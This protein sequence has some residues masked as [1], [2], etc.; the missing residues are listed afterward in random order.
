MYQVQPDISACKA[1][2][3]TAETVN[4]VL[5]SVNEI[6][7]LHRL[8]PVGYS[9]VD[10]PAAMSAALIMVANSKLDHMPP[11]TS[12]CFSD[13]GAAGARASNLANTINPAAISF[14]SNDDYLSDFL[15]ETRNGVADNVGHRRWMLDP[16]LNAIAFGRVA[17]RF[18]G[19][20]GGD[21]VAL[22]VIQNSGPA[23]APETL[24]KFVAYPF[25][26]YPAKFFDTNALLSFGLVV[27]PARKFNNSS[28]D[29]SKATIEVRQRASAALPV[30]KIKYDTEGYGLPNNIQFSVAGLQPGLVYDVT[31]S[32][33]I[34]GGAAS[35]YSYYFRIVR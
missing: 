8:P 31:I 13:P 6:R 14:R 3:H 21:A 27:D 12:L 32:N 34:V 4:Q 28:V 15:I 16:F 18:N 5:K 33:V 23:P 35:N 24:P 1:G 20:G 25:E 11:A 26:E 9:V 17:G 29:Y 10:E 2:Q 30:S 19:A 7:A 22:K